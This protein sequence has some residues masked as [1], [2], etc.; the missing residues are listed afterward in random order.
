MLIVAYLQHMNG[1]ASW[2]GEPETC[3][4]ETLRFDLP[5]PKFVTLR[6]KIVYHWELVSPR[7]NGFVGYLHE[8]LTH[9]GIQPAAY[10]LNQMAQHELF[11]FGSSL[12]D[13]GYVLIEAMG[14]NLCVIEAMGNNLCVVAPNLS[15][16][17]EI[18]GDTGVLYD[19][20]SPESLTRPLAALL[21][22]DIAARRSASHRR[23]ETLFSRA[24]FAES[25]LAWSR[26]A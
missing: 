13:W 24:A 11:V 9:F 8:H 25:L 3:K 6:D 7:S 12:D 15:P 21:A 17:D 22:E 1:M 4:A 10:L 14:N 5:P 2:C 20:S 16:F 18:V 26:P 23:A 19:P